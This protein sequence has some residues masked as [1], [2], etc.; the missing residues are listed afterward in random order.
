MSKR[1]EESAAVISFVLRFL[2]VVY[3]ARVLHF[4]R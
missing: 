3:F 2:L 1:V 4:L